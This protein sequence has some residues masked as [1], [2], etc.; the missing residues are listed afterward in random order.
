MSN[1]IIQLPTFVIHRVEAYSDLSMVN[2]NIVYSGGPC[3][4]RT[5]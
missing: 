3:D 2:C 4:G 5:L 1:S